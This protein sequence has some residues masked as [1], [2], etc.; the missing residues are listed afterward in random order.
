M[1]IVVYA[2]LA[3]IAAYH[4]YS[5]SRPT[6]YV[7]TQLDLEFLLRNWFAFF[8]HAAAGGALIFVIYYLRSNRVFA[9]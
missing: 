7:A 6:Y 8:I 4:I 5:L 9:K 3:L 1:S 2:I